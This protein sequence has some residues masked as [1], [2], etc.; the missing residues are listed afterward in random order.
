M[1]ERELFTSASGRVHTW[2]DNDDG[3][4]TVVS[5][6]DVAP[7]LERNAEMMGRNDGYSP[8]RFLRRVG[9]IPMSLLYLW[10]SVE[11]WDPVHPANSDRLA[12]KLNDI[13]FAKL[14]TAPGRLGVVDGG[15]GFR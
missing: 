13:D 5:R 10:Q 9:S 3:S 2:R 6:Q 8:S 1:S 4:A 7:I 12:Q 14:R 15:E 11:G